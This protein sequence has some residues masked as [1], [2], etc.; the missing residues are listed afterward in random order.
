MKGGFETLDSPSPGQVQYR[1]PYCGADCAAVVNDAQPR[2]PQCGADLS[3]GPIGPYTGI[4][5]PRHGRLFR[6]LAWALLA[7]AVVTVLLLLG[8]ALRLFD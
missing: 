3:E 2:C 4:Y 5:R 1:C 8:S 6:V 7:A